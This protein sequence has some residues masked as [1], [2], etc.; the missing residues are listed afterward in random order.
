MLRAA[1]VS[2]HLVHNPHATSAK[3][4]QACTTAFKAVDADAQRRWPD[5]GGTTATLAVACGWELLVAN[6]GDSCAYLDT[7]SEV[8]Q[9]RAACGPRLAM[10][11]PL[12][13]ALGLPG[14]LCLGLPA[15]QTAC[16][17]SSTHPVPAPPRPPV[18]QVSATHRL[19][20]SKEEVAR[21]KAAGCEIA[22]S[23]VD[24]KPAGPIR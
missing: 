10:E 4:S 3:P 11:L 22:P 2:R 5:R 19:E 15:V 23:T 20:D 6:V 12:W 14:R 7:G 16:A 1:V 21:C 13:A 17:D 24:G 9:V 8:L 18:P